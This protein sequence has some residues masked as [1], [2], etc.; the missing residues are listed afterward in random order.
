MY[1][2][3]IKYTLDKGQWTRS[4]DTSS[5]SE[6][7]KQPQVRFGHTSVMM[8]P[9]TMVV[10]GGRFNSL[11]SDVW[12]PEHVVRGDDKVGTTKKEMNTSTRRWFTTSWPSLQSLL[13]ARVRS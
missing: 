4:I 1:N 12:S 7:Y 2:D 5:S 9:E 10:Y 3:V 8:G 6:G 13:F 11:Y